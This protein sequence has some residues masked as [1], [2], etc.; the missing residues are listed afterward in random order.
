MFCTLVK[1]P[2]AYSG[3][4]PA[5]DRPGGIDQAVSTSD[6]SEAMLFLCVAGV[7]S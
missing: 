7:I 3:A 2:C 1:Q 5:L 4:L 6:Y